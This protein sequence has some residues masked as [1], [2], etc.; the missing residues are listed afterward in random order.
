MTVQPQW[1]IIVKLELLQQGFKCALSGFYSLC[2][3]ASESCR[4]FQVFFHYYEN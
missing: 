3:L 4:C 1:Y 2:P